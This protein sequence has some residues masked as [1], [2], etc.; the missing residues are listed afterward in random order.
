MKSNATEIIKGLNPQQKRAVV[1]GRGPL[2]IIAGAGTGKTSV[3][4]RRIA[5][6]IDTKKAEPGE[7]LALTF[8]DKAAEEMEARVDRLVPYGYIDIS[9]STFHAFGDRVLRDH[10]IDL[11]LTPDYRVLSAAEQQVFFREHIFDFALKFYK[12][13]SDPTRHIEA[14]LKVIS[15]A[16]DEDVSPERYER[17]AV[18]K[19]EE[20]EEE[21]GEEEVER[22]LEVARVYQKYQKLKA[23]HGFVDFADQVG[24]AL[25]LFRQRPKVLEKFQ[26]RYKY[27]LV[28]EFQ[29][30]NYAQFELLK[31]L[32]GTAANLTV[33]GDDDQSIYKFRGAAISNI[34]GF[35]EF[36]P[37]A[38][39]V[40][41]TC[42]YRSTQIILDTAHRLIKHNNPDRL[43]VKAG[44]DKRLRAVLEPSRQILGSKKKGQKELTLSV[45]GGA[46]PQHLH[47]DKLSSEAD[48]VAQTIKEKYE[49]GY[50][51][52]DFA[53]LV[54]ANK[55]AEQFKK[56]LN[57]LVIPYQASGNLGLYAF[58][59]V[60]L[61]LSFL[62]SIGYLADSVSLYQLAASPIYQLGSHDLQKLN[63][64]AK[65]RNFTLHHVFAHLEDGGEEFEV[66]GD[67]SS[68]SRATIN[69]IMADLKFYL[70]FA[71]DRT[72]GELLYQFLKKSGYLKKLTIEE[73]L[74]NEARVKNLAKLFERIME[75]REVVTLDRVAEFVNYIN[76]L[77]EAGDNPE[78]VN[79]DVDLDAVNILTVHK[80]KGLE[81][82][83]VFLV[84]LVDEKFPVRR[85][86]D[87]IE[88]PEELV[89]EPLPAGDHHLQEERRLFY[90]AMTR[91]REE[92]YLT[93]ALDYGGKRQ[94]KISPF[95][96]EALDLPKAD[97]SMIKK[98]PQD[99]LELFAP[100]QLAVPG[101]KRVKEGEVLHLSFY[102]IDDYLTCPLKYK[103]V[104]ILR[105]PLLPNH[106]I[107]YGAALHKAVQAYSSAKLNDQAFS[108]KELL[109]VFLRSWSSQGFISRQH[110]DQRLSA[111]QRS[112]R[113]FYQREQQSD[114]I[115]KYVEEEF[116]IPK[117]NIIVKG[118]W[119]R[120]DEVA[121][122][123]HIVDFKSSEVSDQ[124]KA[125]QKAKSSLQ[126]NIYALVWLEKFGELPHQIELH[127]LESGLIGALS[128]SMK[129]VG[130]TWEKILTVEE[131][132][133][134]ADFT[135]KPSAFICNYCAYSEI[136]PVAA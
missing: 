46:R 131:G 134:K 66:L 80:A 120:V 135:P 48:W 51:Y 63:T 116:S 94:R 27:I 30:T 64:F 1:H 111:A 84:S 123:V 107:V 38:K 73:S 103:Y 20:K 65:R 126:L 89:A 6:L 76:I 37:K 93:S 114:R 112:L 119:D 124:K 132:I 32:A 74:E 90:V 69:K 82:R 115:I 71:K 13:L 70:D 97:I 75:F 81:F 96:L 62:R 50:K 98:S 95:V 130:S 4:I 61:A 19:E 18:G 7:I 85:R 8:T 57:M 12:S 36:Y 39:K 24:L 26:E 125:D 55:D 100:A 29:D 78:T 17:W 110:E 15:R 28:D 11:G 35:E 105:V 34:L 41:L 136:C 83:V 58:P 68:E 44:I 113:E 53:I 101:I 31:L 60:Q 79:V 102:Q 59:E 40:V 16:Q 43:E 14:L 42:N 104:H 92:L 3:L 128:P 25:K 47:F 33:V 88:L 86:S 77:K 129:N 9:I 108:E 52:S 54:R 91:A 21:A 72:T 121:G 109:A 133:R 49:Q 22:Q 2:L 56:S 118:R 99:Q 87:P 10:A 127:F 117:D 122:N 23:V 45:S 67:L 5:Y 106:Q